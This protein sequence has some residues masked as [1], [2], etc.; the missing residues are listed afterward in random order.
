[1]NNEEMIV[2]AA[3]KVGGM[4]ALARELGESRQWLYS[5]RNGNDKMPP[6]LA[7]RLTEIIGEHPETAAIRALAQSASKPSEQEFWRRLGH[8]AVIM[9]LAT[10]MAGYST[11]LFSKNISELE[12]QPTLY[13]M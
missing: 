12:N 10:M 9:S 4:R 8:L 13:I 1:M 7:A 11:S 6:T 3:R 5:V 2:S